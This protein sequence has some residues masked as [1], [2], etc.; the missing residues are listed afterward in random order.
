MKTPHGFIYAIL[1][2][3]AI[4]AVTLFARSQTSPIIATP[5][6]H[7]PPPESATDTADGDAADSRKASGSKATN[8]DPHGD[9]S[10]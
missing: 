7:A 8:P 5:A 9:G 6:V 3:V 2:T 10:K 4:V 1:I